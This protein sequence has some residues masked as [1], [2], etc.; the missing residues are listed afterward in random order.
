[1]W[2]D[3][4]PFIYGPKDEAYQEIRR[5]KG[6]GSASAETFPPVFVNEDA[7]IKEGE[8]LLQSDHQLIRDYE[9]A[10]DDIDTDLDEAPSDAK[11]LVK[12]LKS[13]KGQYATGVR[14]QMEAIVDVIRN[15]ESKTVT[16][17]EVAFEGFKRHRVDFVVNERVGRGSR[18]VLVEYKHW[19]GKLTAKRRTEM[20]ARLDR[21]LRAHIG[22]AVSQAEAGKRYVVRVEWPEFSTLDDESASLFYGVMLDVDEE[23]QEHGVKFYFPFKGLAG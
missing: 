8:G 9:A 17:I 21:Q 5:D 18:D 15:K 19:T 16:G 11:S 14:R 13:K 10:V 7:V 6:F 20:A 23:A 2:T 3:A 4:E 1:L 12:S 22:I